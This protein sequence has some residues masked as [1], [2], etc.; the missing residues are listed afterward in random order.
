MSVTVRLP[1]FL[2]V[3]EKV[4]PCSVGGNA[5]V[6]ICR[7]TTTDSTVSVFSACVSISLR[8][9]TYST[10]G[11]NVI[12]CSPISYSTDTLTLLPAEISSEG[13]AIVCMLCSGS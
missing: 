13:S 5:S 11:E 3:T 2:I 8:R 6:T 7:S 1:L 10:H 12:S 9:A 4:V